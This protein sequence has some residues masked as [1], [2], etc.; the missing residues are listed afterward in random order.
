M[1]SEDPVTLHGRIEEDHKIRAWVEDSGSRHL[2][3]MDFGGVVSW[4]ALRPE[5]AEV[6]GNLLLNLA[7]E[8]R[9]KDRGRDQ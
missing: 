8:A 3:K 5:N 2:V 7:A 9:Q 4:F 1:T 6:L